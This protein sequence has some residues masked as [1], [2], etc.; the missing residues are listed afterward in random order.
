MNSIASARW[1]DPDYFRD[2]Y[3]FEDGAI[4][5]GRNP[6]NANDAIG[7]KD[8][9]HIVVCAGAGSGKGRSFI[10]NNL[11]LWQGSTITYDPKGELPDILAA[12][13]G[14][15]DKYCDGLN[16]DVFVLDPFNRSTVDDKYRGYCDPVAMLNADTVE[17]STWCYRLADSLIKKKQSGQ[18][19]DW[20]DKGIAFIAL[21]IEH[22]VTCPHIGNDRR[23]IHYVYELVL[24]GD[25]KE[26][27]IVNRRFAEFA[28]EKNANLQEGEKP[29]P[30]KVFDPYEVLLEAMTRNE[31]A[32]RFLPMEARALLRESKKVEKYFTHVSGEARE[33]LRWLRSEGIQQVLSGTG[34]A[35][36]RCFDPNRLKADPY[37]VSLF[38]VLPVDDLKENE[39]W[40]QSL[41]VG[42]FATIR[43]QKIKPKHQILTVLDE[44]SSLGYQEYI[45]TSLD[46][47][48]GAGMKIA[49][50]VQNFGKIK[51]LYGDEMESFFTNCGLELYF[52]KIGQIASEYIKKE[53]GD[54][55]VVMTAR[56]ANMSVS[57]SET[58]SE[59]IAFGTTSARGGS[60]SNSTTSGTQFSI[61]EGTNWNESF[62]WA[63][64]VNWSDTKNWGRGDGKSMGSNYGPH[65]FIEGLEHS[66]TY[67]TSLNRNVG[68]GHTYG[69]NRSKSGNKAKGGNKNITKS[70][71]DSKSKTVAST[72]Q[73]STSETKTN[74]K[75]R[76]K[77]YQIGG[78]IAESFH[79]KP[80]LDN[81]EMNSYLRAFSDEDIDH[82]AYPGMML[83]RI[84]GED[85]IFVRRT[86][87]DQDPFFERCFSPDPLHGYL[88][89]NQVPML[90]FQYTPEHIHTFEIPARV[91]REVVDTQLSVRRYQRYNTNDELFT[92][93]TDETRFS[94]PAPAAGRVLEAH[95]DLDENN[96]KIMVVRSDTPLEKDYA[97]KDLLEDLNETDLRDKQ[98][99]EAE[100]EASEEE[101]RNFLKAAAWRK[102]DNDFKDDEHFFKKHGWGLLWIPVLSCIVGAVLFVLLAL[103]FVGTINTMAPIGAQLGC[104]WGLFII[105]KLFYRV[106]FLM[107][108]KEAEI[109]KKYGTRPKV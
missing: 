35:K 67:G 76:T 49:F 86:N 32:T 46:N 69:G 38:I 27:E 82:P 85:P 26:A 109:E 33:G 96:R 72:W 7:Y 14:G 23:N 13:R 80:L 51:K 66:N 75:S 10:V 55:Q 28:A 5:I 65:I 41:F 47:I 4:W 25:V 78:G 29:V 34:M 97:F 31:S 81:H 58:E 22:V 44:F 84:F 54:T 63:D 16:Q 17:L 99:R 106:Q 42:I 8:E 30:E 108:D 101:K 53:I 87:Y 1:A 48:R 90:G 52:G 71:T 57:G 50:I 3:F 43:S 56:N 74:T 93:E 60:E 24:Q 91:Y 94:V 103:I 104:A 100:F 37:G 62:G 45:A 18:G 88:P 68:G 61:G 83:V 107:P 11:A 59:A 12:R 70:N 9:K 36:N 15:G 73:D 20:A 40:L 64:G 105:G 6:H 98:T 95:T 92:Y 77:G 19:Q 39:P 21:I 102:F 2:K 79:K 89:L